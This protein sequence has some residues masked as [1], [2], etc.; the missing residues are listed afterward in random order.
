MLGRFVVSARTVALNAV[1]VHKV[2]HIEGC[3]IN[4]RA[5]IVMISR[6]FISLQAAKR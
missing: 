6:G 4:G 1:R 2:S 3:F 5:A